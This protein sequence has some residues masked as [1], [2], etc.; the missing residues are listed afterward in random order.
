MKVCLD[1][2]HSRLTKGKISPSGIQECE[3]NYSV[4]QELEKYL[5]YNNVETWVTNRNIDRDMSLNERVK[6]C[7]HSMSDLFVSIHKN[8]IGYKYQCKAYGIETLILKKGFN[9]HKCAKMVQQHLINETK[10]L[11]RGVKERN[12]YVLKYTNIPAILVELGFMDYKLEEI[13]MLNGSWHKLY[14]KAICKGICEYFNITFKLPDNINKKEYNYRVV[15]GS[16]DNFNNA[17]ERKEDL[18]NKGYNAFI[19]QTEKKPK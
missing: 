6:S 12:L 11:D 5:H 8:A 1:P 2:G 19:V 7:N 3:Q 17:N 15:C 10:L 18:I 13:Q 9:A 16:F 14:A 4:M